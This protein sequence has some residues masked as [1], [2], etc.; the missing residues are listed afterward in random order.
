MALP[1][2]FGTLTLARSGFNDPNEILVVASE[3][4]N[5]TLVWSTTAV[6]SSLKTEGRPALVS[7]R[8]R[9]YGF[10]Q[11]VPEA[12]D[13]QNMLVSF[14]TPKSPLVWEPGTLIPGLEV[15]SSPSAA[16]TNSNLFCGFQSTDEGD[17]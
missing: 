4:V 10:F 5:D 15:R 8:D 14:L 2:P 1:P 6:L 3:D 9:I 16:A 13:A 12:D 17:G 7:F 11:G